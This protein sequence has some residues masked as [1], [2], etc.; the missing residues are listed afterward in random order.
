LRAGRGR[1]AQFS[2]RQRV[3]PIDDSA[4]L[5]RHFLRGSRAPAPFAWHRIC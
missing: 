1:Y 2:R 4:D 5:T 3:Y